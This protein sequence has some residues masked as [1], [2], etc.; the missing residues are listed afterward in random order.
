LTDDALYAR[1]LD[2]PPGCAQHPSERA[3]TT[4]DRCGAFACEACLTERADQVLLCAEC[5]P[6]HLH[7]PLHW[8]LRERESSLRAV[9]GTALQLL[10]TPRQALSLAPP[11]APWV[12]SL[13]YGLTW[14]MAFGSLM[15]GVSKA[16]THDAPAGLLFAAELARLFGEPFVLLGAALAWFIVLPLADC[17][18]LNAVGVR[19][20]PTA[21]LRAATLSVSPALTGVVP[22]LLVLAA[23]APGHGDGT[24]AS[25]VLTAWLAGAALWCAG[26]KAMAYRYFF[27]I[28]RVAALT[29]VAAPAAAAVAYLAW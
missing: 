12:G 25:W 10:R 21:C 5:A 29:L 13:A 15:L 9:M 8:D 22:F 28:G 23:L 6:R 20:R 16:V 3:Q 1:W 26:L 24:G 14:V 17:G 7:Q 27:R 19:A 2:S 18:V 11:D 4:C